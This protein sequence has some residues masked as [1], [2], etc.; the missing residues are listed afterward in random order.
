MR[1]PDIEAMITCER[2]VPFYNGYRP[3]HL[4]KEGYLTTGVH[5]YY[6]KDTVKNGESVLGSI[7]FITPEAYTYC[8]WEGKKIKIQEGNKVVGYAVVVKI[9]NESFKIK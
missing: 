3:A 9:L 2:N 4:I 1:K 8:L 6:S 7:T 5:Q